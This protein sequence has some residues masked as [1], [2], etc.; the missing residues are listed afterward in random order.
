MILI[1][2]PWDASNPKSQLPWNRLEDFNGAQLL[3]PLF[4]TLEKGKDL[5][6]HLG[7]S[8]GLWNRGITTM[9]GDGLESDE[10]RSLHAYA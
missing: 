6:I 4:I 7:N 9:R 1:N 5:L 2:I 8:E 10:G 3:E